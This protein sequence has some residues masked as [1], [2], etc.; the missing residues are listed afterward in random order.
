MVRNP[1]GDLIESGICSL[2]I[3]FSLFDKTMI[4]TVAQIS[5]EVN[6]SELNHGVMEEGPRVHGIRKSC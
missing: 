4:A 6:V 3:M 1:G 2:L 5:E